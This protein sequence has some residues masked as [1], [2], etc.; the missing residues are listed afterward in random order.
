MISLIDSLLKKKFN[1]FNSISKIKYTRH[2]LSI[3]LEVLLFLASLN[4]LEP[5][6]LLRSQR[7]AL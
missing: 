3:I 4:L 2:L 6:H 7:D 1:K 5:L